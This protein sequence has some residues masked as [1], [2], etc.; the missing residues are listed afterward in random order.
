MTEQEKLTRIR[1]VLAQFEE[2]IEE[3]LERDGEVT[4]GGN[5]INCCEASATF[6]PVKLAIVQILDA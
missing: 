1:K 5:G 4:L 6:R 3:A 2:D